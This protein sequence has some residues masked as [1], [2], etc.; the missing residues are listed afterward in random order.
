MSIKAPKVFIVAVLIFIALVVSVNAAQEKEE[1]AASGVLINQQMISPGESLLTLIGVAGFP[2][3]IR[4][5][6]GKE[7]ENDYILMNYYTYGVSFDITSD[8]NVIKGILIE[9]NNIEIQGVPFKIGEPYKKAVD[10]WGKP[11]K[12]YPGVIV[13]WKRGIYFGVEE[14]GKI[15]HIFITSPGKFDDEKKPAGKKG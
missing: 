5:M 1:Y 7:N 11:D 14:K 6:R 8:T 9:E 13:F 3:H 2:D 10:E 12:E 4:A 15:S